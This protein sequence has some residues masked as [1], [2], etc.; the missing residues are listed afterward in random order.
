M[1]HIGVAACVGLMGLA[2]PVAGAPAESPTIVLG[3]HDCS[4]PMLLLALRDGL[5]VKVS[6]ITYDSGGYVAS[7]RETVASP[8][9][10]PRTLQ[11]TTEPFGGCPTRTAR[12]SGAAGTESTS[13]FGQFKADAFGHLVGFTPKGQGGVVLRGSAPGTLKT[14]LA[15]DTHGQQT[16]ARQEFTVAGATYSVEYSH[17]ATDKGRLVGYEFKVSAKK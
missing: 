7:F 15:Y 16:I 14:D 5:T 9:A 12:A 8:G 3:W 11:V 2:V 13:Q 1:R 10:G 6:E 17:V 4:A